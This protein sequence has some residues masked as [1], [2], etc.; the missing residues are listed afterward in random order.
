MLRELTEQR[1]AIAELCRRFE[2]RRLAVFGSA[3]TDE[4]ASN[5][6]DVDFLV[7]FDRSWSLSRFDAYFGLK[8]G[9]EELLR[10]RRPGGSICAR[11][12][13]LRRVGR[14]HP[15]RTLCRVIPAPTYGMLAELP[16][17]L[18]ASSMVGRVSEYQTDV[19]LRSA[20]ERQFEIIGEST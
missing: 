14:A 19:M 1:V 16:N 15:G 6:S 18:T 4:F 13:V 9:L 20:V 7:E 11:Q 5:H 2:V 3:T 17:R 10:P 12:P 8:E